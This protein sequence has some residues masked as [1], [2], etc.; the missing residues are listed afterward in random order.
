MFRIAGFSFA[1]LIGDS[2]ARDLQQPAFER[3]NCRIVFQ[4]VDA[5]RNRDDG[6]LHDLLC[7]SIRE[8][9]LR[10]AE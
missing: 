8:T 5:L 6:F 4:L 2:P 7:F 1:K 3:T 10:A 9:G